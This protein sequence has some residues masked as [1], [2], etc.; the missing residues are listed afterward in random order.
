MKKLQR[1][2]PTKEPK[3]LKKSAY[4]FKLADSKKV[5]TVLTILSR[6]V[7]H[8]FRGRRPIDY[9]KYGIDR[10]PTN[11]YFNVLLK[12]YDYL[13]EESKG[14]TNPIEMVIED[15]L[16]CIYKYYSKFGKAPFLTQFSPTPNSRMMFDEYIMAFEDSRGDKYW[17]KE[18]VDDDEISEIVEKHRALRRRMYK[19]K[20]DV[21]ADSVGVLEI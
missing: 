13:E 6:E 21:D 2:K 17:I 18:E 15:Y 1:K 8:K 11:K 10:S 7:Q 9:M 14:Y 19:R 4:S 5:R 12:V 20:V 16:T 3:K